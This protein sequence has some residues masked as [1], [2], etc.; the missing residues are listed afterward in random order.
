MEYA[1]FKFFTKNNQGRDFIVG[2]IHGMFSSFIKLLEQVNF[3]ESIDRVFSVG[4]L[5]DRGA[6]SHRAIEFLNKPWFFAIMGNHEALLIDS[7][8][9]EKMYSSWIGHCG[10]DWWENIPARLRPRIRKKLAQLPI[11]MEVETAGGNIGIVHA[12]VPMHMAWPYFIQELREGKEM[13]NYSLWSR[14]RY[15]RIL[16][17]ADAYIPDVAGIDLL[18]VGHTPVV[19]PRLE[20]NVYF[21]DTGATYIEDANLAYLTLLELG[22]VP[23]IHQMSTY[24]HELVGAHL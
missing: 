19:K 8:H 17:D 11:A 24:Q 1:P 23:Q 15:K 20:G 12:D 2:D 21:I 16:S 22:K 5:I 6:E 4:D 7:E 14:N 10:G 3:D 13:R 18:V 9:D